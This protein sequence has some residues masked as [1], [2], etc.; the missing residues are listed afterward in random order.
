M[1]ALTPTFDRAIANWKT[2]VGVEPPIP[3][4]RDK[5]KEEWRSRVTVPKATANT[6]A[7]TSTVVNIITSSSPMIQVARARDLQTDLAEYAEKLTGYVIRGNHFRSRILPPLIRNAEIQGMQPLKLQ[8]MDRSR[9]IMSYPTIEEYD[10]F[11]NEVMVAANQAGQEIPDAEIDPVGFEVWLDTLRSAGHPIPAMPKPSSTTKN[12][13]IGPWYTLPSFWN[14]FYDPFIADP[15]E[16]EVIFER[17]IVPRSYLMALSDPNN[18]NAPYDR[19]SV[20]HGIDKGGNTRFTP[21][22]LDYYSLLGYNTES[23]QGQTEPHAEVLECY[24]PTHPE[25]QFAAI[26]NETCMINKNGANPLPSGDMPYTFIQ[27]KK[28][29]N[30]AVG[31]TPY[32]HNKSMLKEMSAIRSSRLDAVNLTAVPAFTGKGTKFASI[33][34]IQDYQP[35]KIYPVGDH[36]EIKQIEIKVPDALFRESSELEAMIDQG[37]GVT[38]NVRGQQATQGRVPLGESQAR[39][40][41][42]T[43]PLIELAREVEDSI[44]ITIPWMFNLFYEYADPDTKIKLLHKLEVLDFA[45]INQILEM[46]FTFTGAT[47]AGNRGE[48]AQ[49]ILMWSKEFRPILRP[50]EQRALATAT[51]TLL[52]IPDI[53]S[54]ITN[55]PPMPMLQQ[56]PNAM[57]QGQGS[58][59]PGA[60]GAVTEP[61]GAPSG[62]SMPP[63]TQAAVTPQQ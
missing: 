61:T 29:S 4:H 45:K 18:P 37:W 60:N 62:P 36:G 13:Y 41:Q 44:E 32:T 2:Y 51:A 49:L 53:K 17:T 57:V 12:A 42:A 8:W 15:Q 21:H 39:L 58:G 24:M 20:E 55:P 11:W 28:S 26:I 59:M 1:E 33:G 23:L 6:D 14:M 43:L 16:Q 52:G 30:S 50:E 7:V 35:G 5:D 19:N 3:E 9:N 31:H 10:S 46:D 56:D 38:G 34:T 47:Q 27:R 40:T 48:L 25:I 63:T 22:E 54:V